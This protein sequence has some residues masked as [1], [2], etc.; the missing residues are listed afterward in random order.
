MIRPEALRLTDGRDTFSF[1]GGE[2]V[3]ADF[4]PGAAALQNGVTAG[5]EVTFSGY[6]LP[7]GDTADA[8]AARMEVLTRRLCRIV[9]GVGGFV[10]T[11]GGRSIVLTAQRAP[12]FAH[13][14]PLNGDEAAFFTVY[15]AAQNPAAAYFLGRAVNTSFSGWEGRLVFPLAVTAETLFGCRRSFGTAVIDNPG[16]A[17]CG[18]TAAVTAEGGSLS[19]FSLTAAGGARLCVRYPLAFGESLIIDTRPG[20]K[21]VLAGGVPVLSALTADSEFFALQPGENRLAWAT[22]GEGTAGVT[23]TCTPRY[24]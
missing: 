5:R 3:L 21:T 14:A 4:D 24:L 10:L 18:F 9:S 6:L 22:E 17:L 8:R 2:I 19:S 12:V 7:A 16:D 1:D 23:L 11:A 15:A 13:E 20:Q